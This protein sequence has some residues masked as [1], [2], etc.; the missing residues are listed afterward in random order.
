M[1][2][3]IYSSDQISLSALPL[4]AEEENEQRIDI[5]ASRHTN[6]NNDD[7]ETSND[8]SD[9]PDDIELLDDRKWSQSLQFFI[10]NLAFLETPQYLRR[11]LFKMHPSYGMTGLQNPLDT[12]H[13]MRANEWLPYR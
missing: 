4:A 7:D 8:E 12:P 5:S 13:H 11:S 2:H 9:L 10:R 6:E 3:F 1:H